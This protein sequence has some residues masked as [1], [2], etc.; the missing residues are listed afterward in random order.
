MSTTSTRRMRRI[1]IPREAVREDMRDEFMNRRL[2]RT[3]VV[4]VWTVAAFL[5][6][7]LFV[8]ARCFK[9]QRGRGGQWI[10]RTSTR[11]SKCW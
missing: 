10:R 9:A 6:G 7:F 3:T 4:A 1:V 8:V 2:L 11:I 5:I